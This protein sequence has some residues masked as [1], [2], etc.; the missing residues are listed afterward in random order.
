M[1]H[2][3]ELD[4]DNNVLRVVVVSDLDCLDENNEE[5][6]AVG[7]AHCQALFGGGTWIQTSYNGNRRV[8]FAGRGCKYDPTGD[9]FYAPKPADHPSFV[10]DDTTKSWTYPVA[11]P[12]TDRHLYRWDEATTSWVLKTNPPNV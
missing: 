5:S 10:W 4:D 12:T 2:F 6:E 9:Y 7:I 3:A 8:H 11:E 1:A